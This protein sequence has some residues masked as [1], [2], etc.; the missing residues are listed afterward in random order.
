MDND[1]GGAWTARVSTEA[2]LQMALDE[3]GCRKHQLCLIEAIIHRDDCS[4][5]LLEWGSRVGAANSRKP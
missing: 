2:E 3:A 5:Q 1:A 4:K